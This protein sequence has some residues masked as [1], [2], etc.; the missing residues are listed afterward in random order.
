MNTFE[1]VHTFLEKNGIANISDSKF[2][3]TMMLPYFGLNNENL[4]EQPHELS[5]HF[6]GGLGL[7]IW[8]YPNQ[9]GPYL[10]FIS[11]YADKINTYIEVGCRHGGTFV[12]HVE[13]LSYLNKNFKKGVAIDIIDCP[14]LLGAYSEYTDKVEF[15]NINSLSDEYKKY[16]SKNHFNLAFID[17][18]HSY[19]GVKNDAENIRPYS[20]IQV[21]HDI[22]SDVCPGVKQYWNEIKNT[23]SGSY[24]FYEFV[25]QYES[26]SGSFLGIGVAVPKYFN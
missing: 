10:A 3:E 22:F 5:E 25:D 14:P 13:F 17:G 24:D 7:R 18:D 1:A 16:V 4:N 19:E 20:D 11:K 2:I 12:T 9:F 23:L 26:V 8:Q 21:F 15:K 6:G